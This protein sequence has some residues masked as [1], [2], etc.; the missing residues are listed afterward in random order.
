AEG[1]AQRVEPLRQLGPRQRDVLA[2]QSAHAVGDIGQQRRNPAVPVRISRQLHAHP[3]GSR[4]PI[5]SRTGGQL[6]GSAFRSTAPGPLAQATMQARAIAASA[7]GP[8]ERRQPPSGQAASAA[9]G[10]PPAR[11]R[12]CGRLRFQWK[13]AAALAPAGANLPP[14][15]AAGM[16][17]PQPAD[18]RRMREA[19]PR[20]A[21]VGF[22][23][24]AGPSA[25]MHLL[26]ARLIRR[27]R[28]SWRQAP[29]VAA[30]APPIAGL[31]G[32]RAVYTESWRTLSTPE[33]LRSPSSTAWGTGL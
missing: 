2:D 5:Q 26:A 19:R 8:H 31:A 33:S 27:T 15:R 28:C 21:L 23:P 1:F 6:G 30:R 22:A 29:L 18:G 20:S 12:R 32:G 3:L 9:L 10:R 16:T 24:C 11:Q 17:P 13:P 25:S 7:G 14:A 4:K